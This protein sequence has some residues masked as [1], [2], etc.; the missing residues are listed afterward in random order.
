M[1]NIEPP[2]TLSIAAA[3]LSTWK[4][5]LTRSLRRAC[6]GCVVL[7]FAGIGLAQSHA[8]ISSSPQWKLSWSDEFNGA[9]GSAPD[10]AKWSF[11]IGGK[12]PNNE[13]ESYTNRR[14]NIQQKHGDLVI[15]ARKENYTGV[16]GVARQYTSA[17]IRTKGLF[18]QAYGRFEASIKLPLGKGIWPAFWLLGGNIDSVGWPKC[19]EIDIFENIGE[20][21]TIY[22]T[23]H[24]P[25][26]SGAHGI[27][28]K[29][30]LP[31]G[32]AVN[33]GFH[34]YAVEWAP[35]DIKFFLDNK[36]IAERTPANLPRGTTWVYDH[37]FFIILNVAVGG[38][39]PG[40]PDATTKF[41]Q[42]MLVNYVRVYT[43]VGESH[44]R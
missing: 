42:K 38:A 22:S 34:L 15:T 24:G 14:A 1:I 8:Q 12:N 4:R 40:D 33:K 44:T 23:L 3:A 21:S 9:N 25:G 19:G 29:F 17:R 2:S 37:P 28:A 32:Q 11:D 36:L 43:R 30:A 20:P 10:P 6:F 35:N 31:A 16:D 26:Y 18:S 41:P 13:L 27:S 5:L 39:W 7:S